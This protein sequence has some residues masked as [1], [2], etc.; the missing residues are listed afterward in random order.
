MGTAAWHPT[1]WSK[2]QHESTWDRVKDAMKRDWEQT[3]TDL[4][5]HGKEL[6]QDVGDTVKQAAGKEAIPPLNQA[7]A[8]TPGKWDDVEAPMHYG[9]AARTQ[10][11]KTH[12]KWDD[13]LEGTLKSEWES[14]KEATHK[15]WND[16]KS[17]VQHGYE[18][19]RS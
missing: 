1:W 17:Y 18:R 19:A 10:Y 11:G 14:G 13:K 4:A 12:D 8:G 15:G 7:N 5:G 2:D 3:K 6:N 9:Y 16:V